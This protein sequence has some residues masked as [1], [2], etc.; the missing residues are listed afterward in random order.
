MHTDSFE[1]WDRGWAFHHAPLRISYIYEQIFE[2]IIKNL[3]VKG[4]SILELG[5]GSGTIS[6]LARLSG[7]AD[8]T[9]LDAS[10]EALKIARQHFKSHENVTY[11][12]STIEEA[13]LDKKFD[14]VWSS[15]VVEHF[16]NE[17]L[18]RC[19]SRHKDFSKDKVCIIVP[20]SPHYN[21]YLAK[22]QRHIQRWG[23]ERPIS[24]KRMADIFHKLDI[25]IS[26]NRRFC[27]LYAM[28]I[29]SLSPFENRLVCGLNRIFE[30]LKFY[31]WLNARFKP[32]ERWVGGLLLT[33]GRV[34]HN[35]EMGC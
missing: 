13:Q 11:I 29:A 35:P 28:D 2:E 5:C 12:H 26:I 9:L 32:F 24:K 31:K 25:T 3:D 18:I 15:G 14:I 7:A 20:A 33:I 4:K 27:S 23:Y 30:D 6:Y 21:D 8:I 19:V 17:E 10:S 16:K 22:Q 1:H 34:R